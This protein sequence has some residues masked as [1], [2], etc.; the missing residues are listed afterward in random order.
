MET[1]MSLIIG[2]V[3]LTILSILTNLVSLIL[4]RKGLKTLSSLYNF[5]RYDLLNLS[6]LFKNISKGL[7]ILSLF[8]WIV[9][10]YGIV[11]YS[12]I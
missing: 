11:F 3:I 6:D 5:K 7:G 1:F 9:V 2:T 10:I 4:R 8:C 12:I